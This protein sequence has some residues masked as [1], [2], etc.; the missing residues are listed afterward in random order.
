MVAP[1]ARRPASPRR[2][3]T[4][5]I[6]VPLVVTVRRAGRAPPTSP[7]P[8]AGPG[9]DPGTAGPLT[10]TETER[11]SPVPYKEQRG[12]RETADGSPSSRWSRSAA[13]AGIGV[14][15]A[16]PPPTDPAAAPGQRC[17][18]ARGARLPRRAHGSAE[19]YASEIA[20][21]HRPPRAGA[22]PRGEPQRLPRRRFASQCGRNADGAT[23]TRT[24][25][26]SRRASPTAPTTCTTTSATCPPTAT[27]PTSRWPRRAPP[28]GSV[29][30]PP[31]SGRCIRDITA[32][33]ATTPTSPA[34]GPDGNLGTIITPA[35]GVDSSSAA[36]RRPKVARHAAVP[37][38]HHRRREGHHQRARPT[39]GPS[40]PAPASTQPVST[41]QYP[42]CPRGQLGPADHGLRRAAGT[43]PT[44]TA[45]TTARTSRSPTRPP[46]PARRAPRPIPQLRITLSYRVPPGARRTRWTPSRS[47]CARPSTDH[48]DFVNVMPDPADAPRRCHASIPAGA[49]RAFRPALELASRCV[50]T[51]A[52][53][54]RGRPRWYAVTPKQFQKSA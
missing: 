11:S 17:R 37:A 23:A 48:D 22:A 8:R 50:A 24:T 6:T 15:L 52:A 16:R 34:A 5:P 13:A 35:A 9:P 30:S 12:S 54:H 44:P 21:R 39:P 2:P 1:G 25:S 19:D 4:G 42:M 14:R 38:D 33:P 7:W 43:A 28:A 40:G 46:A 51:Q 27:R 20:G 53:Y 31:T 18:P 10:R 26:S 41:T 36:T 29:T 49:A 3:R 32:G 47:S 45:R